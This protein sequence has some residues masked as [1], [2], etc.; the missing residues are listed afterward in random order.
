[1]NI[2][3]DYRP[4][5]AS[6]IEKMN[7][8]ELTLENI[9]DE[10][11]IIQD[12]K[13]NNDSH[14]LNFFTNEQIKKLIDYSTKMPSS[15]DHKIGYKYPFNATEI[16]C[17]ENTNFQKK[18][19]SEKPI[20]Q[21]DEIDIVNKIQKRGGFLAKLFEAINHIENNDED[22]ESYDEEENDEIEI[23]ENKENKSGKVIY[24]N[25]DYL[26]GFL[27]ESEETKENYVLVGYFYKILSN[28]INV[29]SI[30]IVQYLFDYPKKNELDI[31]RL[32]VKHMNR[33]SMCNIIQRLLLFDEDLTPDLEDKKIIL[34]EKIFKELD[35]T[36]DKNKY[37]FI[38][39][40]LSS[41][42]GNKQ[43]F[44]LIMKNPHLLEILYNILI[45]SKQNAK[46]LNSIIKLLTKINDNILQNFDVKY[47]QT[48]QENNNDLMTNFDNY[49]AQNKSLSSPEDN[50]ENLK[51]ILLSLF[52]VLKKNNFSFLDDL[53]NCAQEE[54]VEF[55]S[56]YLEPQ[57]KMGIK[58]IIQIEYI[59]TIIDIFINSY[60]SGYHKNIIEQ[61]INIANNQ[62]IF[63]N[64][65]NLFFLF[66]FSNIYQIYYSQILEIVLN[67]NSPNCLIDKYFLEKTENKNLINILIDTIINN[68]NFI[69]KLTKAKALNPLFP[70]I[71]S[72]LN[73]IYNTQ[74]LHLKLFIEKNK[75]LQAFNEIMGKEIKE[76]F[77]QKLLLSDQG[78][79]FGDS[80]DENLSSFGPKNLLE[81]LEEDLKI[82]NAYK[83]GENY[84]ILLKEKEEEKQK[85]KEKMEKENEIK[86]K[87]DKIE[88]IDD[89]D[90]EDDPLFKVEKV[91]LE[92]ERD[93]FLALLNKPIEEVYKD[94]KKFNTLDIDINDDNNKERVDIKELE[95]D[96]EEKNNVLV[97]ES[98]KEKINN[99]NETPN[100]DISPNTFD[101]QIYHIEYNRKI[102][103]NKEEYNEE[104]NELEEK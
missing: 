51:N 34:L 75:D 18:L 42:M 81:L 28:L 36:T 16:L 76:I 103:D 37:E 48:C 62:N 17:S 43:F 30:K 68:L 63:W 101:N 87:K 53:G 14:F 86:N 22:S 92:N 21:K 33:K 73:K 65:H 83:K 84:E 102:D 5:F 3:G 52:K 89:L 82:F 91:N 32:F 25:V 95:D 31:L 1:M 6:V 12:I 2:F 80:G 35:E 49:Y 79:N 29:H 93:N 38:C 26:L 74:N 11:S 77:E 98:E 27:N 90:E 94:E 40:S 57:K 8:G 58:K 20:E 104:E 55:I 61:L 67:E 66:P 70:Y 64:L 78:I 41:T 71:I 23:E 88:Y 54:N 47:T 13:S 39:D 4:N 46:K 19:M 24:E 15:N 72:L 69:F 7:N 100:E 9:L 44:V 10:D 97:D 56:T 45:N 50:N 96:Y 60:A 99:E 59:R 85:E